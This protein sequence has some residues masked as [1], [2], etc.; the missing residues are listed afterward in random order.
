MPLCVKQIPL[1]EEWNDM[2][3]TSFCLIRVNELNIQGKK[4]LK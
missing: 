3:P 1:P 4:T 2:D